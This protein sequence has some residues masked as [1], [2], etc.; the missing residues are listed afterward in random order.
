MS[1]WRRLRFSAFLLAV[2]DIIGQGYLDRKDRIVP[3]RARVMVIFFEANRP[4]NVLHK[5]VDDF[6]H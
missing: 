1:I 5:L 3:G 4:P 6:I 2:E